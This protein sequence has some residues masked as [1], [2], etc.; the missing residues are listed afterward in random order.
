MSIKSICAILCTLLTINAVHSKTTLEQWNKDVLSIISVEEKVNTHLFAPYNEKQPGLNK[1]TNQLDENLYSA[2]AHLIHWN[3]WNIIR[4]HFAKGELM[5]YQA[6]NPENADEIDN[7]R[8]R[9][10]ISP[11]KENYFKTPKSNIPT[12]A[13]SLFGYEAIN[14]FALPIKSQI[15]PEKDSINAEGNVTYPAAE[16]HWY[17][18]KEIT[19]FLIREKW[20]INEKGA[21]TNRRI[22]AIAPMVNVMDI[23]GKVVGT[24]E[25]FWVDFPELLTVLTKYHILIKRY[26]ADKTITLADFFNDREFF[27]ELVTD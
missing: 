7:G 24:Q 16:F 14:P 19:H 8:L 3:L 1:H 5:L 10:P 6:A 12:K 20:E 9:Y 17:A 4:Y 23:M 2:E 13:F 22:T 15:N 27:A 21:T 18:D 26:A 11:S 25:L